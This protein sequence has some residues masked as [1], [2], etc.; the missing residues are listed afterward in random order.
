MNGNKLV[1]FLMKGN[2]NCD[3]YDTFAMGIFPV[4]FIHRVSIS[5]FY[6]RYYSGR[7]FI[8]LSLLSEELHAY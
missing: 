7:K 4:A 2:L 3:M 8:S 5:S 1:I 6:S